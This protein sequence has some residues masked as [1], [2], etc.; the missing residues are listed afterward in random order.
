ME[1]ISQTIL[2]CNTSTSNTHSFVAQPSPAALRLA[3]SEDRGRN[4]HFPNQQSLAGIAV[5]IL[6]L[7]DAEPCPVAVC[8]DGSSSGSSRTGG[9]E[10]SSPKITILKAEIKERTKELC[11]PNT[12]AREG[13]G[14]E[15]LLEDLF[16]FFLPS[17]SGDGYEDDDEEMKKKREKQRRRDRMRDRAMD[18]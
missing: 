3:S 4:S 18:R 16:S 17:A 11:S 13:C 2:S 12:S 14:S 10:F 8:R 9:F 15:R 1:Y 5:S 6:A 7:C